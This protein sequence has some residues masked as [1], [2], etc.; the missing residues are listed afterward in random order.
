MKIILTGGTGFI[1]RYFCNLEADYNDILIIG[2]RN[3]TE[4]IETKLNNC[5]PYIFTDYSTDSLSQIISEFKPDA[6]IH[7]AAQRPDHTKVQIAHYIT[8]LNITSNLFEACLRTGVSN[9]IN[10]SSRMVYS[11]D[12]M[13]PWHENQYNVPDS[14][15]GLSK[16]WCESAACYFSNIGLNIKTLRLAQVIGLGERE[17]YALQVYL[18]NAMNGLPI[19]I[20]GKGSGK[21]H[22]VYVKDVV[23]AIEAAMLHPDKS[24]VY[25]IGMKDIFSFRELAETINN[26]FGN[27]SGIIFDKDKQA[28]E[29]VY[30]MSIE[31]AKN[32]LGWSPQYDLQQTYSDIKNDIDNM[33]RLCT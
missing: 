28:D 27:K 20:F 19:T 10:A 13:V 25:N 4:C 32:E 29:S 21:R 8:N 22:Y 2:I 11:Q 17:G 1:G 31:K 15:Y 12:N 9:I 16:L 6:I 5:I 24:G 33:N 18:K 3:D 26:T 23:S 7:L 14:Y 30:H